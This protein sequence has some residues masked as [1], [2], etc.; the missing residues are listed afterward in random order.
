[1]ED[2]GPMGKYR[3]KSGKHD[4]ESRC[5]S[6]PR[7]NSAILLD[8]KEC[9]YDAVGMGVGEFLRAFADRAVSPR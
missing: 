8:V 5:I 6:P 1:M 3:A 7:K 9:D 2:E 4:S